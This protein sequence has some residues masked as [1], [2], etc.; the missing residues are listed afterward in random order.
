[1]AQT[2][3]FLMENLAEVQ[4]YYL[5]KNS[6]CI[7]QIVSCKTE[8]GENAVTEFYLPV[9]QQAIITNFP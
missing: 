7:H 2:Y 6:E 8:G 1:M 4:N 5:T 3:T 9:H